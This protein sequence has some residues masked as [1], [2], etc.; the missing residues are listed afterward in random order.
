MVRSVGYISLKKKAF[1]ESNKSLYNHM[2]N[3]NVFFFM[4]I[5]ISYVEENNVAN[6]TALVSSDYVKKEGNE[7]R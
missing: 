5:Y 2:S 1:W 4:K 7:K 3:Y 6:I